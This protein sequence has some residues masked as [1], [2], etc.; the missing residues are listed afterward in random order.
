MQPTEVY[1]HM[2]GYETGDFVNPR[3]GICYLR[4]KVLASTIWVLAE[5]HIGHFYIQRMPTSLNTTPVRITMIEV[6]V[7]PIENKI[8]N[9]SK[10][11]EQESN[12][13][14]KLN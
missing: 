1:K 5:T 8:N 9:T 14:T 13:M 4:T 11:H 7:D 3:T 6:S 2:L 10:Q 12:V